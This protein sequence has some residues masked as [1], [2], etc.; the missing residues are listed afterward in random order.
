MTKNILDYHGEYYNLDHFY[1]IE[2]H[3]FRDEDSDLQSF[4][5]LLPPSGVKAEIFGDNVLLVQKYLNQR[6][7]TN[8]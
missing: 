5:E 1:R 8:D 7:L 4:A 6:V 2:I 3:N